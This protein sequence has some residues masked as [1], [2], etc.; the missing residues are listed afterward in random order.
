MSCGSRRGAATGS[1]D[2]SSAASSADNANGKEEKVAADKEE[3]ATA[4]KDEEAAAGEKDA[5]AKEDAAGEKEAT[6]KKAKEPE[7]PAEPV[8]T[9]EERA[10]KDVE[11]LE[12]KL[13]KKKHELLLQLADFENNKKRFQKER[14]SRR[15]AATVT[16]ARK[17]VEVHDEFVELS[18][19]SEAEIPETCQALHEGIQLTGDLY[20]A[21]FE[22]YDVTAIAPELGSPF[23]KARHEDA[24]TVANGELPPK[25]IAELV[26]PGWLLEAS[27]GPATVLRMATVKLA[28]A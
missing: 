2:S 28:S 16:F 10:V 25:S 26:E 18:K 20:R 19:P 8:L 1:S 3:E 13:K 23:E 14:L 5:S 6:E 15:K 22:R 21:A 12:E 11:E 24:G 7:K 4:N 17:M 27:E 9:E